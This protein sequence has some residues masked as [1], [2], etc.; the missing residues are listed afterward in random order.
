M[1]SINENN[2]NINN[3]NNK[4]SK[5]PKRIKIKIKKKI[6]EF[7]KYMTNEELRN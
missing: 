5:T 4:L 7:P 2:N 1:E 3:I 6:F